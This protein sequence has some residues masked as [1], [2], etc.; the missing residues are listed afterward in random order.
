MVQEA[1]IALRTYLAPLSSFRGLRKGSLVAGIAVFL[2]AAAF[3]L[4]KL[5]PSV[6]GGLLGALRGSVIVP[7]VPLAA[8]LVSE[9]ALREGITH[10]TLL[11]PLLGPVSRPMT[12]VV[13]TIATGLLLALGTSLFLVLVVAL[14]GEPWTAVPRDLAAILCGSLA[15]T[16]LFGFLHLVSRRGLVVGLVVYFLGDQPLA[17]LPFLLRRL[18]PSYHLSVMADRVIEMRLPVSFPPPEPHKFA[19]GLVL[20]AVAA[21]LT[22]LTAWLFRRKA[23]GELC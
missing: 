11:Y 3:V 12:A 9:M 16:A 5:L 1:G 23:L 7:G 15:Y 22:A 14:D 17:Q 8:V 20:V 21:A 18:S 2:T 6:F 13:R 19:S 10:R 4:S